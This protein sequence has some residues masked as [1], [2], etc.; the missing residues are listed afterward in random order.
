MTASALYLVRHGEVHNPDRLRYG[1]QPGFRLSERGRRE[2]DA[3]ATWLGS[4]DTNID[5]I[6][7]SPL[8]RAL[9]TAQRIRERLRLSCDVRDD[10]RLIEARS[11][12]DGLRYRADLWGHLG[13]WFSSENID[14]PSVAVAARVR[15]ALLSISAE[16][17]GAAVIVSHQLPIQYVQLA[18][19]RS[20]PVRPWH[21]RPPCATASVTVLVARGAALRVTEHWSPASELASDR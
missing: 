9:E 7:A 17:R 10:E 14:E 20:G 16:T 21:R 8:E 5:L 13:R 2:V 3:C 6:A 18:L 12:F 19:E 15:D 11:R 4:R 1:R